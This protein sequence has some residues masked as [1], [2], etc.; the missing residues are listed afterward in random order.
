MP[1]E[2]KLSDEAVQARL[3]QFSSWSIENAELQRTFVLPTFPSA[4]FFANAVAYIA[5]LGVHHPDMF[6][7]Y[8]KVSLRFVTHSAGGITDKDFAMVQKVDELWN[9]L[10]SLETGSA[11]G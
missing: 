9:T 3:R 7:S 11:S 6:I 10:D 5:E 8:N 4:I 1:N 2:Q